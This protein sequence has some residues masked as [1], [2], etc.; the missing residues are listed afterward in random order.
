VNEKTFIDDGKF[1]YDEAF[2]IEAAVRMEE[3]AVRRLRNIESFE[4]EMAMFKKS[5]AHLCN[6]ES[7]DI[8][9]DEL[10]YRDI[11]DAFSARI[12]L[13]KTDDLANELVQR[14]IENCLSEKIEDGWESLA[15]GAEI[16][17][18][19]SPR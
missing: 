1:E 11:L 18:E 14:T 9:S 4:K 15:R 5:F 3:V 13:L 16:S 19:P 10:K 2:E 6:Q 8:S 17:I 7:E 12:W